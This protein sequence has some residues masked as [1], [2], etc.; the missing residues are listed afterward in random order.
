MSGNLDEI[1][2][3]QRAGIV[4]KTKSAL[5]ACNYDEKKINKRRR[6]CG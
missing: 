3:D 6:E 5:R 1:K 2:T 4:D